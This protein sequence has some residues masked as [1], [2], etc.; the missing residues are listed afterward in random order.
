MT[1]IFCNT[2][3]MNQ[4]DGIDGD[5]LRDGG[6]YNEENIG[7]EVCN[8]TNVN[9]FVYGYVQSPG[10]INIERLGLV[11]L[12]TKLIISQLFGSPAMNVAERL[13]LVG[14]KM[15]LYIVNHRN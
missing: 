13:L 1:I 15:Q 12:I 3:W 5:S 7:L 11:N 2:G 14:I 4:Y 6:S 10:N 9:G 8:F